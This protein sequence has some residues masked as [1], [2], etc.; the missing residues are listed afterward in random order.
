MVLILAGAFPQLPPPRV[1]GVFGQAE[2]K[3]LEKHLI[4]R[5]PVPKGTQ[6]QFVGILGVADL[7]QRPKIPGVGGDTIALEDLPG[8]VI[9]DIF[10]LNFPGV[11]RK[12]N[13]KGVQRFRQFSIRGNILTLP[14]LQRPFIAAHNALLCCPLHYVLSAYGSRSGSC[15]KTHFDP[16]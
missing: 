4:Q 16:Y 10:V 6:E 3:L 15:P 2:L 11:V 12:G 1:I 7:E 8:I 9:G 14:Q 5:P 13:A